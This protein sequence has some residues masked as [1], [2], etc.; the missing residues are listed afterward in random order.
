MEGY[1]LDLSSRK[2]CIIGTGFVGLTLGLAFAQRGLKVSFVDSNL[3]IIQQLQLAQSHV[4]EPGINELIS[5]LLDNKSIDFQHSDEFERADQEFDTFIIS[6]GTPVVSGLLDTSALK[7]AT[8]LVSKRIR[9]GNLVVVRSTVSIGTSRNI[10]FNKLKRISP[11]AFFAT[12]P[13]RTAEGAAMTEIFRI[14]QIVGGLGTVDAEEANQL[15]LQIC[16]QT[17]IV[18]SP[19]AAELSKLAS[20]TYRDL[21]F[22]FSNDLARISHAHDVNLYE[23]I[24]ACNTNYPRANIPSPGPT[25]GPCLSKD[26]WILHQSALDKEI[27]VHT[28]SA[29]RKSNENV[30]IEFLSKIL[31]I[32]EKVAPQKI[33]LLGLSFKGEPATADFRG[34]PAEELIPYLRSRFPQAKLFGYENGGRLH[35]ESIF[36]TNSLEEVLANSDLVLVLTNS[37]AFI[38][39]EEHINRLVRSGCL[40]VDFW[41]SQNR[42]KLR[43]ELRHHQWGNL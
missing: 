36:E 7:N 15:F 42:A 24:K 25:G 37:K 33:S 14:P 21:I 31:E 11:K 29:A 20:N 23:V 17:I 19:E 34:S 6:V 3:K 5:E 1:E 16:E 43:H 10:V 18:S 30:V 26:S 39:I 28:P 9:N 22:G 12:C 32:Y 27:E 2:I 13:E 35:I 38:A 4:K 40:I 8:L 41:G